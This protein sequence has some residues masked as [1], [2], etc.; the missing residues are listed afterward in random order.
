MLDRTKVS[1]RAFYRHFNSKEELVD[2]A[3]LASA[4]AERR[5]LQRRMSLSNTEVEAV[6]AWIDG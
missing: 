2:A 5:R 4:C 3:F 6:A 1:T